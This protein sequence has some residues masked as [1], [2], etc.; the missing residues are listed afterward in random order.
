[1]SLCY[2]SETPVGEKLEVVEQVHV[3]CDEL[4]SVVFN[5]RIEAVNK[6]VRRLMQEDASVGPFTRTIEHYFVTFVI[7][8]TSVSDF[9]IPLYSKTW[10]I[11]SIILTSRNQKGFQLSRCR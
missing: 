9:A 11:D 3:D 10:D 5:T 6:I 1:M 7:V 2:Q 4:R 8:P